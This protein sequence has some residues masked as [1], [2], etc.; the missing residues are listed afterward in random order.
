MSIKGTIV[1]VNLTCLSHNEQF[2]TNCCNI[3]YNYR[4]AVEDDE[5]IDTKENIPNSSNIEPSKPSTF[6]SRQ[7]NGDKDS[8]PVEAGAE[9]STLVENGA[10][11]DG[12]KNTDLSLQIPYRKTGMSFHITISSQT[13]PR[14]VFLRKFSFNTLPN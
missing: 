4:K 14:H 7:E 13:F 1:N 5:N 2:L 6:S 3:L 8:A 12:E 9:E 10:Q 11:E